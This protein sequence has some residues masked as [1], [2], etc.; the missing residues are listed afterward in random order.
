LI[1]KAAR[2]SPPIGGWSINDGIATI[3]EPAVLQFQNGTL[4]TPISINNEI[5]SPTQSSTTPYNWNINYWPSKIGW[6]QAVSSNAGASWLFVYQKSDWKGI[7]NL[8]KMAD[9]KNYSYNRGI[10]SSVS[11]QIQAKA[12][13]EVSKT[14]FYIIL[15]LA[16]IFLWVERK[17]SI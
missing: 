13:I 7:K 6:N 12:S 5:I 11:K 9:T 1:N 15:L 4:P 10:I 3:N 17:L 8:K 14:F 16:C 2:K